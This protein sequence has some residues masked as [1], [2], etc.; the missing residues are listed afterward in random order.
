MRLQ[1]RPL[2]VSLEK[3][4]MHAGVE[5]VG[6]VDADQRQFPACQAFIAVLNDDKNIDRV[7]GI[8]ARLPSGLGMD[9]AKTQREL[10]N[11]L[12]GPLRTDYALSA[13]A[14]LASLALGLRC[15]IFELAAEAARNYKDQMAEIDR[16]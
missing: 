5:L 14:L 6:F 16:L 1:T 7:A 4:V 9:L 13:I 11:F 15:I 8:T 10:K 3:V 2:V 12:E